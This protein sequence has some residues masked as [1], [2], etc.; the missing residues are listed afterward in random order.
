[1][2]GPPVW[3][4]F[5]RT[6][7]GEGVG[8]LRANVRSV[9]RSALSAPGSF[10]SGSVLSVGGASVAIPVRLSA[11]A[12]GSGPSR[13]MGVGSLWVGT[14]AA[15]AGFAVRS[16]S[17]SAGRLDRVAGV[18]GDFETTGVRQP[19]S[20]R[21]DLRVRGHEP[22]RTQGVAARQ[23]LEPRLTA[24]ARFDVG[25]DVCLVGRDEIFVQ[26]VLEVVVAGTRCHRGNSLAACR[27]GSCTDVLRTR[28]GL[29]ECTSHHGP[30]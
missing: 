16:G 19:V 17:V 21:E 1:M 30:T 10:A 28:R 29:I 9:L 5:G 12:R 18:R 13:S 7:A 3:R 6:G 26:E 8:P 15:W 20:L 22:R 27:R 14:L 4:P 23:V 2:V 11:V 24:L 25:D